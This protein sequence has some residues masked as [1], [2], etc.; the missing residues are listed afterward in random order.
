LD[1]A[2]RLKKEL[3]NRHLKNAN[4]KEAK[5]TIPNCNDNRYE[6]CALKIE[7]LDRDS[8]RVLNS[9]C[10]ERELRRRI[11]EKGYWTIYTEKPS[12]T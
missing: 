9:I 1:E 2:N 7:K 10:K 4:R 5:I 6:G 12:E 3:L 11:F 8:F